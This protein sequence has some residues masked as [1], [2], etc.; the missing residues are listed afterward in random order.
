MNEQHSKRGRVQQSPDLE[1]CVV[2]Q[3]NE[4]K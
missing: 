1:M 2:E 3:C 4:K